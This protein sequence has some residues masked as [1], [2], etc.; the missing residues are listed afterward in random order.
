[1]GTRGLA[2]SSPISFAG[3]AFFSSGSS[4]RVCQ[5]V[6]SLVAGMFEYGPDG[7]LPRHFSGPGSCPG[8]GVFNGELITDR[9]VGDA[10]EALDQTH[11]LAGSLKCRPIR[12]VRRFDD[13]CL[14][15]PSAARTP[16]H[17]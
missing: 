15:L 11:L 5:T 9:V 10:C 7:L 1:M 13:K 12:E 4:E 14:A 8:G 6:V 2:P 16:R 3:S 17:L